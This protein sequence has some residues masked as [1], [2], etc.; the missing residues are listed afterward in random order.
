MRSV[1]DDD[2][3]SSGESMRIKSAALIRSINKG[4]PLHAS[5][6]AEINYA[7]DTRGKQEREREGCRE[8]ERE[9]GPDRRQGRSCA[10]SLRPLIPDPACCSR[11]SLCVWCGARGRVAERMRERER[12]YIRGRLQTSAKRCAA[13]SGVFLNQALAPCASHP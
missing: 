4:I 11:P 1:N 5:N 6:A 10:A 13:R 7:S 2:G 8:R 3:W 9:T 12:C